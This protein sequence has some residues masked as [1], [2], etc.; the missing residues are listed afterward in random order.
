MFIQ[1]KM[2]TPA[3]SDPRQA[4][5]NQILLW[6]MPVMFGF[7]TLQFPAGLGIYILFSNVLGIVIQYYIAPDQSKAALASLASLTSVFS[8]A[9]VLDSPDFSRESQP[10]GVSATAGFSGFAG[11]FEPK[12]L[13]T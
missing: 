13:N 9:R 8:T 12:M 1:Q 4:Q 10:D 7:F 11:F 6:T 2:S 5:T 3:N